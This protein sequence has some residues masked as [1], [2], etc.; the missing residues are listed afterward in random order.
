MLK[1]DNLCK[2]G[3]ADIKY[4]PFH[5][6]KNLSI[7]HVISGAIEVRCVSGIFRIESGQTEIFNVK[8]PIMLTGLPDARV[9]YLCFDDSYLSTY[10]INFECVTYNCNGDNFFAAKAKPEHVASLFTMMVRCVRDIVKEDLRACITNDLDDILN[11][12][13]ENFD[14]IG[15]L[16]DGTG[17][18]AFSKERFK[19]ISAYMISHVS[20]RISLNDIA[21]QEFLSVPYLSKEFKEH[22]EQGYIRVMNYY[23]TINSVIQLLDTDNTLTYIAENSGFSSV[24][25]Y[26]KIFTE[27]Y[28]QDFINKVYDYN[29]LE[30]SKYLSKIKKALKD[31][32]NLPPAS[33]DKG[34]CDKLFRKI[35][36]VTVMPS[37]IYNDLINEENNIIDEYTKLL[38][39]DKLNKE[40]YEKLL[41]KKNELLGF[42][43]PIKT[44]KKIKNYSGIE[45]NLNKNKTNRIFVVELE[46]NE[47]L[48]LLD[49]K[50]DS[51][52]CD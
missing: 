14:D 24:R 27:E 46:Y 4:I 26:N 30:K 22:L 39:M 41:K 6:C 3:V 48:G 32:T 10:G 8:E 2:C 9:L 45:I 20:E 47:E 34:D 1:I 49:K 5:V 18:L 29:E 21:R 36:N 33:V 35:D 28:K 43:V 44:Y 52:M 15:H 38:N 13:I 16:F 19:R 11:Y 25:Y 37:N 31:I 42:T 50:D 12:V 51:I 23:R 17:N 7:I 40:N